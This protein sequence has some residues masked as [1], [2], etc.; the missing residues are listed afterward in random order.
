MAE[1]L[2][3]TRLILQKSDSL[4]SISEIY[5]SKLPVYVDF[6]MTVKKHLIQGNE[7]E[8]LKYIWETSIETSNILSC[9]E[10]LIK[11]RNVVCVS[12]N[13]EA[14]YILLM[15]ILIITGKEL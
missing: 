3:L 6:P 10:L 11:N 5:E 12:Y 7:N 1:F 15:K 9:L 14:V 8:I 4:N 13:F 2:S